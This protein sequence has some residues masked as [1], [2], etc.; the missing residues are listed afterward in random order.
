M[1]EKVNFLGLLPAYG[2][3]NRFLTSKPMSA[4][5]RHEGWDYLKTSFMAQ[6]GVHNSLDFYSKVGTTNDT[7]WLPSKASQKYMSRKF[8]YEA[9]NTINAALLDSTLKLIT[10]LPLYDFV[11]V[12]SSTDAAPGKRNVI[13]I[14]LTDG[15]KSQLED[16]AIIP[17]NSGSFLKVTDING[18]I[19]AVTEPLDQRSLP[20]EL[21]GEK[22][23]AI[24]AQIGLALEFGENEI[25]G[26]FEGGAFKVEHVNP[27]TINHDQ[28][29]RALT[30]DALEPRFIFPVEVSRN[31]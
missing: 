1:P 20:S 18:Q 12:E 9:Y 16:E 31:T 4:V 7:S 26:R 28:I 2:D 19:R 17:S 15:F 22:L 3:W 5:R 14:F 23:K 6:S 21:K 27:L 25:A 24:L 30:S 29:L 8:G 11:L 10:N 13:H